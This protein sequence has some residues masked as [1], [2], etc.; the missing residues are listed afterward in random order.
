MRQKKDPQTAA[1]G[2][3][4]HCG[5]GECE[6]WSRGRWNPRC[7]D[8][9]R[10]LPT[11]FRGADRCADWNSGPGVISAN[12]GP[13]F[14]PACPRASKTLPPFTIP[15][16]ALPC[17]TKNAPCSVPALP[18]NP[19]CSL[20]R[21][22]PSKILKPLENLAT[23]GLALPAISENLPANRK[24]QGDSPARPFRF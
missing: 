7:L 14:S 24:L 4:L 2:R 16:A 8:E 23:I 18:K 17:N 10:G 12:L 13:A 3:R 15:N 5:A 20:D 11:L 21:G 9:T 22:S 6:V 1:I 19:P